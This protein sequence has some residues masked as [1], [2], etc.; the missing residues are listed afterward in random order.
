MLDHTGRRVDASTRP[1]LSLGSYE[2]AAPEGYANATATF[3]SVL[4]LIDVSH[5]AVAA[6]FSDAVIQSVRQCIADIQYPKTRVGIA[7]YDRHVY[8]FDVRGEQPKLLVMSNS[9]EPFNVMS[10]SVVMELEHNRDKLNGVLDLIPRVRPNPLSSASAM[11]AAVQSS[12]EALAAAGGGRLIVFAFTPCSAGPG[13]VRRVDDPRSAGTERDKN[14]LLK[15]TDAFYNGLS[16]AFVKGMVSVDFMIATTGAFMDAGCFAPLSSRTGGLCRVFN[17][18]N[19]ATQHYTLFTA[20]HR[21]VCRPVGLQGIMRLRASVG[22]AVSEYYGSC[23]QQHDTDVDIALLD[24]DKS[25]VVE[26]KIEGKAHAEG[27]P[28]VFQCALMYSPP[29]TP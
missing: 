13:T 11:G 23:A 25:M 5:Q 21:L 12:G 27:A 3:P 14:S 1:E 17:Q 15:A 26:M 20:I 28:A 7:M 2:F 19:L 24:P 8:F 4:F 16:A 29:R 6:G 22:I 18:F 10:S 9:E